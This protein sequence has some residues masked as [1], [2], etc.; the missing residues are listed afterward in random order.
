MRSGCCQEKI[1]GKKKRRRREESETLRKCTK[2][3]KKEQKKVEV[4]KRV[5][6]VRECGTRSD[7]EKKNK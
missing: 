3:K 4:K 1:R 5:V 2:K 7:E 6:G